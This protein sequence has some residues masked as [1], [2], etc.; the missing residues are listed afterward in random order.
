[1]RIMKEIKR[2]DI[3]SSMKILAAFSFI[4]I[5]IDI[6]F[7]KIIPNGSGANIG[8][9]AILIASLVG[10]VSFFI[11]G[12]ILIFIYNTLSSWIGGIKVKI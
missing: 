9:N 1:M 8:W 11:L 2:I 4:S 6:F 12:I 7:A 10:A 5:V 3:K